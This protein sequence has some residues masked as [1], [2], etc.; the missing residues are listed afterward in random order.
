MPWAR[1]RARLAKGASGLLVAVSVFTAPRVAVTARG[2][3]HPSPGRAEV[4]RA[5]PAA[6][7]VG[8]VGAAALYVCAGRTS[9][10]STGILFCSVIFV[11]NFAFGPEV[12][13]QL[14]ERFANMKEGNELPSL[15]CASAPAP[16]RG[17]VAVALVTGGGV[18]TG[19]VGFGPGGEASGR[20]SHPSWFSLSPRLWAGASQL[21]ACGGI[22]L[23]PPPLRPQL[24]AGPKD[25]GGARLARELQAVWLVQI[26]GDRE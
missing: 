20:G 2:P 25:W 4:V 8:V 19:I 7:A 15:P 17:W 3:R 22:D 10:H 14:K 24:A 23:T 1:V 26:S 12:D 6:E 16:A 13:H 21:S 11:N 5:E 18:L 9:F